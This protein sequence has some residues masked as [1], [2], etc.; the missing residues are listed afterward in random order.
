MGGALDILSILQNT[1]EVE[2]EEVKLRE[3]IIYL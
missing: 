3:I 2:L 1:S